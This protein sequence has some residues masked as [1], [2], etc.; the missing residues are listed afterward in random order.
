MA[1]LFSFSPQSIKRVLDRRTV[2]LFSMFNEELNLVKKEFSKHSATLILS[3]PRY[4]GRATWARTLKKRIDIPMKVRGRCSDWG[5]RVGFC[6][7]TGS[8]I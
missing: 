7:K 6:N 5:A 8:S 4:A 2:D 3:Q 1:A